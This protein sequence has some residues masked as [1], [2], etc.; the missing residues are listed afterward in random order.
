[1]SAFN[2]PYSVRTRKLHRRFRAGHCFGQEAITVEL[3][4]TQ[5]EMVKAD[6][7]LVCS[8]VVA[9]ADTEAIPQKTKAEA[10]AK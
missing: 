8:D 7:E 3:T 4:P 6:A 9:S 2:K 10:K 1:M 5:A